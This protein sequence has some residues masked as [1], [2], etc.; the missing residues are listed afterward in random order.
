MAV[1]IDK[2]A[3]PQHIGIIMDGNGRW[4]KKRGLPRF[5]GHIKGAEVF[6]T[7][8]RHCEKLGIKALTVYAFS[9]ENWSR[10]KDEVENI[11]DLFRRYLKD[12]FTFE[13]ETIRMK[14]IGDRSRL[15]PELSEMMN[16]L[17]EIS[18]DRIG[19]KLNIAI[20]YGGRNEIVDAVKHISSLVADGALSVN[21]IDENIVESFMQTSDCPP[22]DMILRPS[23][24]QRLSNF[25]LWQSAYSEFVYMDTLWP[26]FTPELLE[27]AIAEYQHRQ[28]RFGGI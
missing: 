8:T 13:G 9:T 21:D 17:E 15:N 22:V 28:R 24:E 25:M 1:V 20:N 10:P 11:M 7:I 5:S 23:G 19:L 14:F 12:A 26:D 16:E 27:K 18:K 3:M 6:K 2:V 4:A